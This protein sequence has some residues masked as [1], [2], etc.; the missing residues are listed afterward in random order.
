M[1]TNIKKAI[2]VGTGK[3]G[4]G[5]S[6]FSI[7]LALELISKGNKV[8]LMDCDV[9]GPSIPK[10]LGLKNGIKGD[11]KRGIIPPSTVDG[12]KVFS[13]EL[14][15]NDKKTCVL[16]DGDRVHEYITKSM[17]DINW[18]AD[19][20]YLIADLPPGSGSSPQA[21]IEFIK[22]NKISTGLVLI[23]TPQDVAMNDILKSISMAD[24]LEI[25]VLGIVEN[26]SVFVCP[27]CNEIH[28][29]FGKGK[30]SSTCMKENL[31]YLGYIPLIP[32]LSVVSDISL[33]MKTIPAEIKPYISIITTNILKSLGD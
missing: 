17:E 13:T 14:F 28:H 10:I 24:K 4:V 9:S 25:P 21:I 31:N 19:I 16:W 32:E 8:G 7:L 2:L 15:M 5:K 12:L 26:M 30:V 27:K 20:D 3:G 6:S 22:E 29:L 1:R 33:N 23:T 11:P 18:G